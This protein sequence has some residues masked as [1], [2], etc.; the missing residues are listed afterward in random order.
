[1][2]RYYNGL[3]S[4]QCANNP[5]FLDGYYANKRIV[6]TGFL[7]IVKIKSLSSAG[8]TNNFVLTGFRKKCQF[9]NAIRLIRCILFKKWKKK[10]KEKKKKIYIDFKKI[11]ISNQEVLHDLILREIWILQRW[12]TPLR[13][14]SAKT[15]RKKIMK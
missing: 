7:P 11:I 8:S 9:L 10:K 6:L 3:K 1:M 13:K 14:Q 15:Q 5:I 2:S 4:H 12:S